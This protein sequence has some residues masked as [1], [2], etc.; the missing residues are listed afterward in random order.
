MIPSATE[1]IFFEDFLLSF[2][3]IIERPLHLHP[4]VL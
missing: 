3:S 1:G 2:L 4:I